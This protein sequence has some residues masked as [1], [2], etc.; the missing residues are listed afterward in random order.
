MGTSADVEQALLSFVHFNE[1]VVVQTM[2]DAALSLRANLARR[3]PIR[4]GRASASWNAAVN[5]PDPSYRQLGYENPEGA[6]K[7]GRINIDTAE[8]GD[9]IHVSNS[10]PYIRELNDGSAR[11]VPRSFV[12][13]SEMRLENDMPMIA[14]HAKDKVRI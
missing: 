13:L 2:K 6:P 14:Q 11:M 3:T 8:L 12:Q 1:R 7:D 5:D 10:I 9:S 4:T